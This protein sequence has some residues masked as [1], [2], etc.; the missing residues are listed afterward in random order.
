MPASRRLVAVPLRDELV[1]AHGDLVDVA[2]GV[3]DAGHEALGGAVELAG[4]VEPD[5]IVV[6]KL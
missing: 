3:G 1:L 6:V 5:E 2:L 4:L